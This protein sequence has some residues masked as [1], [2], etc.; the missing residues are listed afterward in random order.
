MF[1]TPRPFQDKAHEALR[2]GARDKHRCQLIMAPTGAGK[3]ILALRVAYEALQK[4]KRAIFVADRITLID[5]TSEVAD[6]LG[7]EHGV[8]QAN[9]WRTDYGKPFQI[10]SVQTLASR[11]WPDT[12]IIIQDECHVMQKSWTDHVQN[13]SAHVIGLSATPFASHDIH[14]E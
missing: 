9:H 5:Q 4:G 12:D 7:I 6:R 13:T 3:S 2:S 14:P 10:A 8:I 11:G 1:P